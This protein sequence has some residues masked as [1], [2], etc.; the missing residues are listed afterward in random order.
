MTRIDCGI[1]GSLT[2]DSAPSWND[3]DLAAPWCDVI[4]VLAPGRGP[5]PV[6]TAALKDLRLFQQRRNLIVSAPT[7]AGKTLIGLLVLLDAIYRGQRAVLLEPLRAIA[8]EK[9]EELS[10]IRPA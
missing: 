1:S 3:F 5:K 4:H 9:F 2:I 8:R 6:Q 7:N 10:L